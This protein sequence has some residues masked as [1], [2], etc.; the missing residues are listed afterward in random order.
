MIGIIGGTGVYDIVNESDNEEKKI[1]KTEYGVNPE[2]SILNIEGK[3]IA[4][5]PRHSA[6]HS[7]PPHK[8]NYKANISALKNLGVNQ[9]IATNSVGSVNVDIA[10]GSFV[11]V[12]DFLDFTVLRDRT[13]YNKQVVHVDFTEPYCNRLREIIVS[14]GNVIS[15]GTY[16]CT[17]GPR[18]ETPAEIAMFQ[19]IGGDVV[20]MTGLP[21]VVLAREKEMC[22][23]SICIVSN[24]G[25][26]ISPNKLSMD[27]VLEIMEK[28]NEE[29]V[30]LIYN[31]IKNLDD[32]FD[33]E[34]LHALNNAEI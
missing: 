30:Q 17:E 31:T 9:I 27:E 25:T 8:I 12:D 5:L 18:F 23:A 16:V 11:A 26:G 2:V 21:E 19:K 28:K 6:G 33:C 1:V 7:F 29:L 22:Y 34:C 10:P 14:N 32:D 24:Y 4:F 15:G 13:F 20:G 3:E